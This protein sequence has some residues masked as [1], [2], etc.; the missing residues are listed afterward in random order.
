M[1]SKN[2]SYNYYRNIAITF[3][4]IVIFFAKMQNHFFGKILDISGLIKL[5]TIQND[6]INPQ[7]AVFHFTA[8]LKLN[9]ICPPCPLAKMW[10]YAKKDFI[11]TEFSNLWMACQKSGHSAS[12]RQEK[13]QQI[14]KKSVIV[15]RNESYDQHETIKWILKFESPD[16]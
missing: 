1:P 15:H 16:Y 4:G 13:T 14:Y 2:G 10:F 5:R 9:E 3:L 12:I 8:S 7:S 6:F 11:R